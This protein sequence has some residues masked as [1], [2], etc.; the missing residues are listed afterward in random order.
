MEVKVSK[1]LKTKDL[2]LRSW[3]EHLFGVIESSPKRAVTL[4][5]DG[6]EFMSRS[7][8]NEYLKLKSESKKVIREQN[9][10]PFLKDM[11]QFASVKPILTHNRIRVSNSVAKL[12]PTSTD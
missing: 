2:A 9:V 5:F 7:F 12:E 8:A 4:N 3:A 6:V 10:G 11:F 1:V